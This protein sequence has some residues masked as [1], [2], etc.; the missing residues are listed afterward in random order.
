MRYTSYIYLCSRRKKL[1]PIGEEAA[2]QGYARVLQRRT[3]QARHSVVVTDALENHIGNGSPAELDR[4]LAIHNRLNVSH[5]TKHREKHMRFAV[6]GICVPHTCGRHTCQGPPQ[7][8]IAR[9]LP[10]HKSMAVCPRLDAYPEPFDAHR[11]LEGLGLFLDRFL[12]MPPPAV[13]VGGCA[14]LAEPRGE[15]IG[16][17]CVTSCSGVTAWIEFGGMVICAFLTEPRGATIG[18]VCV[19]SCSGVRAWTEFGGMVICGG[20]GIAV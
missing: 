15:T 18:S 10:N 17:D 7:A 16:P 1:L 14:F 20:G 5:I 4:L 8:T 11:P 6:D 3:Q 13:K 2:H 9:C 12:R 19:T